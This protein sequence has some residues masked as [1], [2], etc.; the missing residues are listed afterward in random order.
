M[1]L[2]KINF[3]V[4]ITGVLASV[5]AYFLIEKYKEVKEKSKLTA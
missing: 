1:A 4:L 3:T 5:I 2:P